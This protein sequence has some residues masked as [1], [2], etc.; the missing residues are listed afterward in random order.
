MPYVENHVR[1]STCAKTNVLNLFSEF[2]KNHFT[3]FQLS[4]L[5]SQSNPTG[6]FSDGDFIN[7]QLVSIEK[8]LTF[9]KSICD[10]NT[11]RE[12][13]ET[14]TLKI[15]SGP[16]N[17]QIYQSNQG[18]ELAILQSFASTRTRACKITAFGFVTSMDYIWP[19]GDLT[20]GWIYDCN[21]FFPAEY[22]TVDNTL[23]QRLEKT[24]NAENVLKVGGFDE[25]EV[26]I[27]WKY[28]RCEGIEL[29]TAWS[30]I[31]QPYSVD[32]NLNSP[33]DISQNVT[34]EP[35]TT[36]ILSF[37]LSWNKYLP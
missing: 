29:D 23:D 11:E 16:A 27:F 30:P 20:K 22:R 7:T 34:L 37:Y 3:E 21:F 32:L 9:H 10:N 31:S 13:I 36:Y 18:W 35:N 8:D 26:N 19:T 33:C 15:Q 12:W 24:N 1:K 25:S 17:I 4:F 2:I 28:T 5:D 14:I 6:F